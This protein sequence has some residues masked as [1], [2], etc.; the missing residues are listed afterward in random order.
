MNTIEYGQSLIK[1][2]A[3]TQTVTEGKISYTRRKTDFSRADYSHVFQAFNFSGYED[4]NKAISIKGCL[5]HLYLGR[6]LSSKTDEG[7][8]LSFSSQ[9]SFT[10]DATGDEK[11]KPPE[12]LNVEGIYPGTIQIWGKN[13][14]APIYQTESE[15]M[16]C[17]DLPNGGIGIYLIGD[18]SDWAAFAEL[19]YLSSWGFKTI[20]EKSVKFETGKAYNINRNGV[21]GSYSFSEIG[22]N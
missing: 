5:Y 20:A 22:R 16:K 8:C 15:M 11:N 9:T 21:A 1:R 19:D 2:P 14:I 6:G 4:S 3:D 12:S 18:Y 10:D 7:F 13:N 17:I